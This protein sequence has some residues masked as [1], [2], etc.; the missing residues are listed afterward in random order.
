M[1]A[2]KLLQA[3]I[4]AGG[5]GTRLRP[6]TD[7]VPKPM[8][9][10]HGKPFLEYLINNLRDQGILKILLLLGYLPDVIKNYFGNGDRFGVH[11]EYSI[12]DIDN[13]TGRRMKLAEPFID[14]YFLFMYCD[15]YWPLRLSEMLDQ[16]M[17]MGVDGQL[18]IYSNKDNY[19][20]DN[21]IIDQQRLIQK[22]DKSRTAPNLQGVDIG[23]AIFKKSVLG[24]LPKDNILFESTVYPHLTDANQLSAYVTDHRYYS[25]GSFERLE[26]TENF[27]KCEPTIILDRDGVLNKKTPKAEYVTQWSKFQWLPG[28]KEALAL[29]KRFNYRIIIVT[30]QA[31]ISRGMMTEADLTDI[32][33]KMKKEAREAGG[34]IDAIYYCPHGWDENCECRKPKPGMFFQ[35]QRDFHLDLTKTVFIGDDERDK[36]A[37]DAA[38]CRTL[39]VDAEISLLRIVKEKIINDKLFIR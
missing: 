26:I 11:I 8:I 16:Y 33:E 31:G 38:G 18:T 36:M 27:L 37:G 32:H 3:V 15:N 9:K 6:L 21:V 34:D 13:D 14:K 10:F 19:T 24:F 1:A 35:A 7:A 30:N 17:K 39:L 2:L 25:V 20:R 5:R 28:A 12:T 4:L 22:Y 29:L 23:Y